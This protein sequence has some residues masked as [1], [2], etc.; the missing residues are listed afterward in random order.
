M[1]KVREC[2]ESIS[3]LNCIAPEV[4]HVTS[5]YIS[6]SGISPVMLSDYRGAGKYSLVVEPEEEEE[7]NSLPQYA[8]IFKQI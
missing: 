3:T 5:T 1:G 8:I 6:L 2:G 7:E 4:M